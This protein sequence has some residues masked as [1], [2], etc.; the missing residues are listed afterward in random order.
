MNTFAA[1]SWIIRQGLHPYFVVSWPF[2]V[3]EILLILLIVPWS[4]TR[5]RAAPSLLYFIWRRGRDAPCVGK[6]LY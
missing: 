1:A 6:V 2:L 3:E 4:S 5:D